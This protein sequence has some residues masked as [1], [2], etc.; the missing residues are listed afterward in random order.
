MLI[1]CSNETIIAVIKG[2]RAR[3]LNAEITASDLNAFILE[4]ERRFRWGWWGCNTGS[5][6]RIAAEA[7]SAATNVTSWRS[8]HLCESRWIM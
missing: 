8:I 7:R 6:Y 3:S 5:G 1:T 4:S 2:L